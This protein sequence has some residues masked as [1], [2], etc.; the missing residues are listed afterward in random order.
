MKYTLI[1]ILVLSS[2]DAWSQN[3]TQNIKGTVSDKNLI[4]P[5]EGVKLYLNGDSSNFVLSDSNGNYE[6][7]NV[8]VGRIK[9]VAS[10]KFYS[11]QSIPNLLLTSG[12]E[13]VVNFHLE[14][15]IKEKSAFVVRGK[16][17]KIKPLNEMATVSTR[18]FSV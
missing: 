3:F 4:S 12:K 6:F 7:K 17:S 9:I 2:F 14:E 5:I 16:A 13:L 1:L 11:E 8:L 18:T 15:Q 10:H